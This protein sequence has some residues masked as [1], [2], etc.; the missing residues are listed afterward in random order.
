MTAPVAEHMLALAC[1]PDDVSAVHDF[2]A[3]VWQHE[4]SVAAEDRMALELALVELTSN[5]IEHG[6]RPNGVSCELRLEIGDERFQALLSDDGVAATV[7]PDAAVLPDDFAE[8]GR[9]LALVRMVV[10]DLRYE[11]VAERN[12]WTVLRSRH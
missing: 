8:G 2:L 7:D 9:G 10:D 11:R 3:G 4:P 1:P 12:R 5:V 6:A